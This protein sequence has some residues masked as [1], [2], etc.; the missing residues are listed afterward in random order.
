M[1]LVEGETCH[2]TSNQLTDI[3]NHFG[4]PKYF[5]QYFS[6]ELLKSIFFLDIKNKELI[7]F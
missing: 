2:S 1:L 5:F 6:Q 4:I 7:H 3:S